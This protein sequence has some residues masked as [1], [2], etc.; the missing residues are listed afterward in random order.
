MVRI[1][2]NGFYY[3]LTLFKEHFGRE[4]SP[5]CFIPV[6]VQVPQEIVSDRIM[7]TSPMAWRYFSLPALINN[8]FR[9]LQL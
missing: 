5:A 4:A 8:L 6:S 2:H 9:L 1:N 7:V 3:W